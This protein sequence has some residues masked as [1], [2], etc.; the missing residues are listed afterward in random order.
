MTITKM[1]FLS[2]IPLLISGCYSSKPYIYSELEKQPHFG[3][4]SYQ[5]GATGEVSYCDAGL[6][7]LVE[8]RREEALKQISDV[9]KNSYV[10]NGE[11]TGSMLGKYTGGF[12]ITPNC[13]RGRTIVFK[14]ASK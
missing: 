13:N 6:A 4:V 8:S 11:M 7:Q 10:I 12:Q 2:I 14:C 5:V 9:C 3:G 1:I